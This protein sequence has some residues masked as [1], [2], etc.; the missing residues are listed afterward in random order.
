[1]PVIYDPDPGVSVPN[2]GFCPPQATPNVTCDDNSRDVDFLVSRYLKRANSSDSRFTFEPSVT[3]IL[4]GQGAEDELE[5]GDLI[6]QR[7]GPNQRGGE[8]HIVFFL[9]WAP[10]VSAAPGTL[11]TFSTSPSSGDVKWV[12][13]DLTDV[14]IA[15]RPFEE[16]YDEII[17]IPG[18]FTVDL[19]YLKATRP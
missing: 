1:M 5:P 13:D 8:G 10:A 19:E 16:R 4:A 15:P 3:V 7:S 12:I 14:P 6:Y 9:G 18:V 2:L 17:Q 11:P